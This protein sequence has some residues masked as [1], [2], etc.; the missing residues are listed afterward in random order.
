MEEKM[1]VLIADES[2]EF[3]KPCQAQLKNL[4]FE[5]VLTKKDGRRVIEYL[6]AQHFD[7][8]LMDV[9]MGGLDGIE[10]LEYIKD[11]DFAVGPDYKESWEY[12]TED[13]HS[14]ERHTNLGLCFDVVKCDN[15][16]ERKK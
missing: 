1:K 5:A 16:N 2:E 13:L 8:V 14:L 3:G 7:A 12:I 11:S 6:G 4:G 10:V 15:S 9:F